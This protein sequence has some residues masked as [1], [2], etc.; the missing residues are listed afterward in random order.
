V[1]TSLILGE[2]VAFLG[3]FSIAPASDEVHSHATSTQ[4]I[5][6]S[7]SLGCHSWVEC[8]RSQGDNDLDILGLCQNGGTKCEWI[9]PR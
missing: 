8:I 5:Q 2:K 4:L 3:L 1:L 7:K 6:S 9:K